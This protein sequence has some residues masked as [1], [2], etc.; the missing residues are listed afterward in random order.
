[1]GICD[2]S[3]NGGKAVKERKIHL[4]VESEHGR[5]SKFISNHKDINKEKDIAIGPNIMTKL[6]TGTPL[7]NYIIDR[8]L[9]FGSF[10][11]NFKV[12]HRDLG[13]YRTMKE[14][15]I[16]NIKEPEIENEII[17]E[18]DI[19]KSLDHPNIEKL[20]EFYGTK[21]AYYIIT[22]HCEGG[23]L[24]DRIYK[25]GIFEEANAAYII[26]QVLSSIFYCH[27]LNVVHRDLKPENIL[28]AS[29]EI[30]TGFYNIKVQDFGVSKIYDKNKSE[31]K[32]IG[33]AYYIAPEILNSKY[34]EKCDI[35]ACGVILYIL[36]SGRA[37]FDGEVEE[38]LNKIK[39]GK[40]DL[41]LDPWNKISNEAKDLIKH[42]LD[43]N[44]LSRFSAQK[45]I[46]HKWFKKFK[47]RERFTSI[48]SEKLKASIENIKKFHADNKLQQAALAFLVHNS[49]HLPEV[50]ELV[51]I[52]QNIDQNGDGRITKEEMT[53]ALGKMYGIADN[54]DEVDEIFRN[55]DNDN[56]GFIEYEEYIRAS[57]DKEILLNEE[58]LLFTFKFFDSD[59][60]GVITI[61]EI[62]N[63]L[64]QGNDRKLSEKLTKELLSK[65]DRDENADIDYDEFKSMMRKLIEN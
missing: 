14:I 4:T 16:L 6:N 28:I 52:F 21:D 37:P 41:K 19:L 22:E 27:N 34:N 42:M 44:T 15:P 25:N 54:E 39:K 46:S 3:N 23:E 57:I 13:I 45:A 35:W 17:E 56:N 7:D 51:K 24:L 48:G 31:N 9:G 32:E 64:F 63:V 29:E 62:S 60:S 10:G 26:Y 58:I 61:D 53:I 49:L 40:Y 47:M 1:M 30:D 2:S 33:S 36:L 12:L 55:V 18:I 8:R 5:Q 11:K 38:I 65:V 43:L 59:G 50:K 20:F